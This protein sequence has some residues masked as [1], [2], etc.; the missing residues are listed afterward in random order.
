ML[1]MNETLIVLDDIERCEMSDDENGPLGIVNEMVENLHWHVMLVRSTPYNLNDVSAEKVV[2]Q[3][4]QYKPT[5]MELYQEIASS[6]LEIPPH[7]DF[8]IASSMIEGIQR[9]GK[10]NAR[11]VARIIPTI[12]TVLATNIISSSAFAAEGKKQAFTDLVCFALL[13]A[14]GD[15]P[16]EPTKEEKDADFTKYAKAKMRCEK[17]RRLSDITHLLTNGTLCH[18]GDSQHMHRKLYQGRVSGFARRRK[19]KVD[20]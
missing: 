12:N 2:M 9:S 3:Q 20:F 15:E 8:D 1:P 18:S 16:V 4:F 19:S 5:A 13:A 6:N 10:L 11:A 17:Y 14:S 7:V